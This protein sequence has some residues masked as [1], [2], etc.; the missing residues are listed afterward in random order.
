M[1][2]FGW[3]YPPGCTSRDIDRLYQEET[4]DCCGELPDDCICPTCE[5]CGDCGNRACYRKH[6]LVLNQS[7][8]EKFWLQTCKLV[9]LRKQQEAADEDY[10]ISLEEERDLVLNGWYN[11]RY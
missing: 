1:S 4:C 8:R 11:S 10:A 3:D 5:E 7:Q 2:I 9:E 6:N